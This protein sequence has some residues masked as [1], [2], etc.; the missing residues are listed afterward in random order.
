MKRHSSQYEVT[1]RRWHQGGTIQNVFEFIQHIWPN[2]NFQ[3]AILPK[4]LKLAK[5]NAFTAIEFC[6]ITLNDVAKKDFSKWVG[7]DEY[8]LDALLEH[9]VSAGYKVSLS[10]TDAQQ[11]YIA[12][13]TCKDAKSQNSDRCVV[14]RASTLSKAI[15]VML[16]KF[17]VLLRDIPWNDFATENDWG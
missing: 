1:Y 6:N 12:S 5:N 10:S 8:D 9:M 13:M 14:S 15:D 16:Y 11:T 4:G 7:S 17:Y 2:G 3:V